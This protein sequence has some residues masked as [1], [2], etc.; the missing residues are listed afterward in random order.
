[1]SE[2]EHLEDGSVLDLVI[3]PDPLLHEVSEN[4]EEI[5]DDIKKLASNMLATM[6]A[7]NAIGLAAVQVGVL[8][9]VIVIDIDHYAREYHARGIERKFLHNN[10]PLVLINA[11]IIESSKR[12]NSIEEG[13]SSLPGISVKVERPSKIKVKFLD[14]FG[15]ESEIKV[16]NT[17][18]TVCIQHEIDHTNG[19]VLLDYVS[20][21]KKDFFMMK[22]IKQKKRI[23]SAKEAL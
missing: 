14:Y 9:K 19:I 11:E 1:M 18:L 21:F 20:K 22:L 12:A 7:N 8:K 13:C 5:D 6:Y 17:L 2:F 4:V 15:N 16:T 23:L 3:E 10:K